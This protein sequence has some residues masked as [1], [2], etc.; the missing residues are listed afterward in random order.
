[1]LFSPRPSTNLAHSKNHLLENANHL[2]LS[3]VVYKVVNFVI[4][5]DDTRSI[6]R[7][8]PRIPE[9]KQHLIE[10]R[11]VADRLTGFYIYRLGLRVSNRAQRL[12]LAVV[13]SAGFAKVRQPV[14]A[15]ADAMKIS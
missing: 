7:L 1:M 13:E 3:L 11:D 2:W 15:W 5:V 4:P 9:E 12:K 8:L 6:S 14:F 10:V